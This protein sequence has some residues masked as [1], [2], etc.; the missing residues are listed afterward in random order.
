MLLLLKIMTT[1]V[2]L[3][4]EPGPLS[5][6]STAYKLRI[7]GH[8]REQACE[9]VWYSYR[10]RCAWSR[11]S[12]MIQKAKLWQIQKIAIKPF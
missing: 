6:F 7:G 4:S 2:R 3:P 8:N 9:A 12:W 11:G 1:M 5:F 10:K